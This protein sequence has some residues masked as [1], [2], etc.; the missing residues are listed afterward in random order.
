M[1]HYRFSIAWPRVLPDG[2]IANI[3]EAGIAYYNKLINTILEYGIEP[4]ATMYHYDLPQA[5]QRFG[6]L[7]NNIIVNHFESYANL[8]F[9]RFGDRVKRWITFNEPS[10]FCLQGYGAG[11]KPPLVKANGIGEYLCANNVLKSHAAAYRLYKRD[12]AHQNGK[13]GIT[14]CTQFYYSDTNR[15]E[16]VNRAMNFEV[17]HVVLQCSV[18]RYISVNYF[19][20]GWFANPIFS[21]KGNYPKVMIA[22]IASNSFSEGRNQSRLPVLS[23]GWVRTIRGSADFLGLNYYTSR[24]VEPV[25]VPTGA[26]PSYYGD[27]QLKF[28]IKPEWTR[29]KSWWLYSV[30]SGIRDLLG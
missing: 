20:L 1:N 16:D 4:V 10:V 18:C 14:L 26:S 11:S 21:K 27:T 7:T 28:I 23:K 12:F 15:T 9:Q 24:Y 29:A 5:L 3:N 2:D 30:P 8:L 25:K 13:L 22:Q 19:Q 6:G 17:C